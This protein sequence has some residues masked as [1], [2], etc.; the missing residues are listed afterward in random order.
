MKLFL[1][2]AYHDHVVYQAFLDVCLL[3]YLAEVL[4][5]CLKF[6]L[7]DPIGMF[8]GRHGVYQYLQNTQ[9]S[10]YYTYACCFSCSFFVIDRDEL[11]G[12]QI[13]QV[14]IGFYVIPTQVDIPKDFSLTIGE[15]KVITK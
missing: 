8:H 1:I 13:T 11:I 7:E 9:E 15:I 6:L 4:L 14:D 10:I 5:H 2:M 12:L 3:H